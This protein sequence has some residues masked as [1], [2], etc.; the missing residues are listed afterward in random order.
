VIRVGLVGGSDPR[1]RRYLKPL[2]R[3]RAGVRIVGLSDPDPAVRDEFALQYEL[4][5]FADHREL[6][7]AI[8]PSLVAVTVPNPGPVVIDALRGGADVLVTPP[9]CLT[10]AELDEISDLA[11]STGR[12]V[13]AAHLYRGHPASLTAR[14]IVS[15]GSLG[16]PDLVSLIVA[17]DVSGGEL[18]RIIG[19]A[20]DLFGWLT[21]ANLTATAIPDEPDEDRDFGKLILAMADTD[22][23]RPVTLEVR[24]RSDLPQGQSILQVAGP[25]GAVEWDVASG[26]L[27]SAVN[28]GD[29][30]AVSCGP[31][32]DPAEWVLTELIRK[33]SPAITT[34]ESLA[35]TRSLL[36]ATATAVRS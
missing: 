25:S 26:V 1:H 24:R 36:S 31:F 8:R 3:R 28:G 27:R 23:G 19:E 21:G 30:V 33:P 14:E 6:L 13:T 29:P 18:D 16:T 9:V 32:S 10:A 17:A 35:A 22:P 2:Q 34:E 12:R 5:V 4:P 15:S 20:L 11:R 7:A